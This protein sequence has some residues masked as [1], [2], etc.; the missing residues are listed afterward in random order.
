MSEFK[1]AICGVCPGGCEIQAEVEDGVLISVKAAENTPFGNLCIRGKAAPEIVY[2]PDRIKK[3]LI[4]VGERGEGRFRE[5]SWDEALDLVADKMKN[6]SKVFGPQAIASHSGRG[7]FEQAMGD[8]YNGVDMLSLNLL[9]AFGSPNAASDGSLCYVSYGL[10]APLTTFGI[11]ATGL[12]PDFENSN[13]IVIWGANPITDSPPFMFKRIVNAQKNGKKIIAIDQMKSD[14]ATRA[15]QW[16]A[17]RSGTDGALALGLI[18]VVI[19]ENIYDQEF[20]KNWTVGFDELKNYVEQ[21][22]PEAV[23]KITGVASD[24]IVALAREI[25]TSKPVTLRTYTGLEY[26]NS[27]VQNIR[28]VFILWALTGNLD[29]PGGLIIGLPPKLPMAPVDI[30]RHQ[31]KPFGAAEY[32]LFY[33]LIGSAHFMEF[34]K[35]VLQG[36]PYPVKGL[37][38]NGSSTL[39]SYPQPEI[40][41]NAYKNLDLMVV[42]DRFMTKDALFADVI[43][44]ATTY[45]EIDSYQ[46][47]PGG[48]FRLRRKVIEPVGEAKNDVLIMGELAKRLGFGHLYPQSEEEILTRGFAKN[49]ELLGRLKESEDGIQLPKKPVEYNKYEKGLLRAD[50]QPGFQT[51]SGKVEFRSFLL[52]KNGYEGLPVYVDPIEG[53]NSDE[54]AYKEYPL[55][56]NTGARIQSTFRSQHLSIPSLVKIQNIPQVLINPKDADERSIKQGDKVLIKTKRGEVN[57]WAK[58][59]ENVLSGTVEVNQGGGTGIQVKE[60][61]DSNVNELTDFSNRDP[62]SGFPIFKALLCQIEKLE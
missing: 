27:G 30:P 55:I 26:S 57:F 1:K 8:F 13:L 34:P 11:P 15:D 6:I 33:E 36:D 14:I 2:S 28:A 42:I 7:A 60:W 46:R 21:F 22:T 61:Q 3:P 9:Q 12:L 5:A 25:A 56:L 41:E 45:F 48:Y 39:T 10:L 40:F 50:G 44:P 59:T 43:L 53:P 18:N 49:P 20:V 51:P 19:T 35:A 31:L 17:V 58:V 38:V 29:I 24:Q 62:I 52:E 37:I 4:R 54:A 23:E 47:Y 32:P 16:I